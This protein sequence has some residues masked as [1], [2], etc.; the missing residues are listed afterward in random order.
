MRARAAHS[1]TWLWVRSFATV[2][3]LVEALREFKKR[4][5]GEWLIERHG[6]RTPARVRREFS[7]SATAVA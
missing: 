4:Y 2:A 1:R 3:E 7:G 6:F 5:N